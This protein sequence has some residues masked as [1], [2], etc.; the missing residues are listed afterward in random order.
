[1][2]SAEH[3]DHQRWATRLLARL[4]GRTPPARPSPREFYL[5][6]AAAELFF[7]NPTP[8]QTLA[9][10]GLRAAPGD[11][12]LLLLSGCAQETLSLARQQLGQRHEANESLRNAERRL[13]EALAVDP[14]RAEA[15]LRL[16]RVLSQQERPNEAEPLLEP[17]AKG[18]T[19][20]PTRYLALLFLGDLHER[21]G[22][23]RKAIEAY[24]AALR[25]VPVAQAARVALAHALE[26]QGEP[27]ASV[28][29]LAVA[30]TPSSSVRGP[31]PWWSYPFG[32]R[33]FGLEPLA[34][35]REQ[36]RQP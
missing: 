33:S 6:F 34:R 20:D 29:L 3:D 2:S 25:V 30:R 22:R 28:L 7:A 31:D 23:P 24:Q 35:L 12:D 9:E 19:D 4:R 15:R 21:R 32:P 14:G 13:R 18:L 1:M 11:A 8:A 17:L 5:A 26:A 16:G 27:G 36:V 10:E